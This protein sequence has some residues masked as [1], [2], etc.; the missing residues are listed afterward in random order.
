VGTDSETVEEDRESRVAGEG[1]GA[2]GDGGQDAPVA[3]PE[4]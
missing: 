4:R 2:V 3:D 1:R